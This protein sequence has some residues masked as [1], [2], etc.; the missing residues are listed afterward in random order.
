MTPDELRAELARLG[1]SQT[2]AAR[3]LRVNE[4]TVRRWATGEIPVPFAVALLLVKLTPKE[5]DKL[6]G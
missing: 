2:G 4:K 1:L 3:A 6:I 5:A